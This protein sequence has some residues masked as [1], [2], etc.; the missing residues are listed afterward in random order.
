MQATIIESNILALQTAAFSALRPVFAGFYLNPKQ[1]IYQFTIDTFPG[2]Y[3][4]RSQ[5]QRL[6]AAKYRDIYS[7]G[8]FTHE[9]A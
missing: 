9:R 1:S 2:K 8:L 3:A 5:V 4:K 6:R 7:P